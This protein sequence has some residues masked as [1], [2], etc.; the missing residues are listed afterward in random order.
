[1]IR[2]FNPPEDLAWS[3]SILK[4]LRVVALCMTAAMIMVG[5]CFSRLCRRTE[6]EHGSCI[7]GLTTSVFNL[8][9]ARNATVNKLVSGVFLVCSC[10][11]VSSSITSSSFQR[12][13]ARQFAMYGL[14]SC[15]ASDIG[16]NTRV[17]TS[18]EYAGDGIVV[19]VFSGCTDGK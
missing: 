17:L 12:S 9:K 18:G 2:G 16:M 3:P 7:P 4:V 19:R 11:R 6:A 10:C 1:M 5:G 8:A 15:H 13:V 14:V